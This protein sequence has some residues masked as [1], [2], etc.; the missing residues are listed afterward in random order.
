LISCY[1]SNSRTHAIETFAFLRRNVVAWKSKPP[2]LLVP[3]VRRARSSAVRTGPVCRRRAKLENAVAN[4][5]RVYS[6]EPVAEETVEKHKKDARARGAYTFR[7][8][9][10]RDLG[11]RESWR[12]NAGRFMFAFHNVDSRVV[13]R[14]FVDPAITKRSGFLRARSGKN[15][16]QIIRWAF[17][18]NVRCRSKQVL[19]IRF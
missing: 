5:P 2:P 3:P 9:V 7:P 17:I 19:T 18:T 1:E 13:E 6:R 4:R 12:D 14:R 16:A 15:I 10:R 8:A 11:Q